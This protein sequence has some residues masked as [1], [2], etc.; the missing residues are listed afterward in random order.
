MLSQEIINRIINFGESSERLI[1][2]Q[3]KIRQEISVNKDNFD[4]HFTC[5]T[6]FE[7]KLTHFGIRMSG[8]KMMFMGNE[9]NYEIDSRCL[10][11]FQENNND[12]YILIEKLS[13]EVYK[14]TFLNFK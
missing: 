8:Q 1:G 13:E 7:F 9:F 5:F 6:N 3:I 2:K 10:I 14:K 11:E 4:R 12:E